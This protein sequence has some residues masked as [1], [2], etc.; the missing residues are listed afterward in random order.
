M[1]SITLSAKGA[2]KRK[3][4]TRVDFEAQHTLYADTHKDTDE[5]H[6]LKRAQN[7]KLSWKWFLN[8]RLIPG[9]LQVCREVHDEALPILY[10]RNHFLFLGLET[11]YWF[12]RQCVE[13]AKHIEVASVAMLFSW[14]SFVNRRRNRWSLVFG[15]FTK[16]VNLKALILEQTFMN[17]FFTGSG[18]DADYFYLTFK[19]WLNAV[20]ARKGGSD[21]AL[22]LLFFPESYQATYAGTIRQVQ[23]FQDSHPERYS[24]PHSVFAEDAFRERVLRIVENPGDLLYVSNH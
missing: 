3:L 18:Y 13:G 23:V 24:R 17:S 2:V 7:P 20:A 1:I 8:G 4:M 9:L 15:E 11:T 19:P 12:A 21:H 10:A 16:F 14:R 5:R 22:D 6:E